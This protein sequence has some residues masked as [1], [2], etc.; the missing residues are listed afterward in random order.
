MIGI[1]H[2]TILPTR[3]K[4]TEIQK[5]GDKKTGKYRSQIMIEMSIPIEYLSPLFLWV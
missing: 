2:R 1:S 5:I 4:K 3:E